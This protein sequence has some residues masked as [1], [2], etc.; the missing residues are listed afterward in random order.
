MNSQL[1]AS[2][3]YMQ[4]NF[5]GLAELL[6]ESDQEIANRVRMLRAEVP[7]AQIKAAGLIGGVDAHMGRR[8][9]AA[10]SDPARAR[11]DS[12]RALLAARK[13]VT[14]RAR[15]PSGE[16]T[17]G[18]VLAGPPG[19]GKSVAAMYI[20]AS[21][22]LAIPSCPPPSGLV[23]CYVRRA[24]ATSAFDASLGA[25]HK[26]HKDPL[27][28]ARMRTAKILLIDDLG[29]ENEDIQK[30]LRDCLDARNTNRGSIT[31]ITT[32]LSEPALRERYGGAVDDRI[33]ALCPR[34][35]VDGRSLRRRQRGWCDSASD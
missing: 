19:V 28:F 13:F 6:V 29:Q 4:A 18:L 26:F 23:E 30:A 1:D 11:L 35:E 5:P 33:G 34:A 10:V 9:A 20:V 14:M 12:T 8:I 27:A 16:A 25:M 21:C 22:H 3:D 31:L 17:R 7:W 15:N 2:S 24:Y 32:N